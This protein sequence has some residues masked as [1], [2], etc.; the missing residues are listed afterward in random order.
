MN[1]V[2]AV[3]KFR[4]YSLGVSREK[5]VI[6]AVRARKY[7]RM[8]GGKKKKNRKSQFTLE[9]VGVLLFLRFVMVWVNVLVTESRY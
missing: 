5:K 4:A 2:I 6:K 9:I 1:R 8:K 7:I 3:R